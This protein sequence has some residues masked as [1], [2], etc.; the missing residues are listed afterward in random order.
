MFDI[1]DIKIDLK[2]NYFIL[3][4]ITNGKEN[5]KEKFMEQKFTKKIIISFTTL[6]HKVNLIPIIKID[7]KEI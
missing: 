3:D 2:D 1:E 7:N 4:I 5:F 6:A